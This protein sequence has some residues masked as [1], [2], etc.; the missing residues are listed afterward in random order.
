MNI[1]ALFDRMALY[2]N[3]LD[4]IAGGDD[5]TRGLTAINLVQDWFEAVAA[6]VD[7]LLQTHSTFTT[8][9]NIETTNWPT[10]LLRLDELWLLDSA[11][12]QVRRM[13]PIEEDGGH[14]PNLPW[15][16]NAVVQSGALS[17]GVPY[18]FAYEGQGGTILWSPK[19]DAIYTIRG[20]G[21]WSKADYTAAADTFL[22]PDSVALAIVPFAVNILRT[23]L[24][25]DL[26]AI[27]NAAE[28]AFKVTVK[29]LKR[30]V[31]SEPKS[32]VYQD[33]HET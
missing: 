29:S 7:K 11:G 10:G 14:V 27:Q 8:T 31:R 3:Q 33:I 19:P 1:Q 16:L 5:V 21:L 2:D 15:P 17:S 12:N 30:P 20:Y 6:T 9:A 4:L 18:E 13:D 24:E 22:Y 32:R 26:G 25:R 23:G 28:A